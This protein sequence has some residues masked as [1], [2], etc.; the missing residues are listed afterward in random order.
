VFTGS[1]SGLNASDSA[2]VFASASGTLS[3]SSAFGSHIAITPSTV[4]AGETFTLVHNVKNLGASVATSVVPFLLVSD[5]SIAHVTGGPVPASKATLSGGASQDFTWTLEA[6][7]SG[8]VV[9][10]ATATGLISGT[11]D[12]TRQPFTLVIRSPGGAPAFEGDAIVY[13]NPV[14]GDTF[15]VAVRLKAD[16][17]KIDVD[18]YNTGYQRV[19]H[20]EYPAA[21]AG[22]WPLE[23]AGVLKWAPGVYLIRI[24]ATQ[25]DGGTQ[26]FPTLRVGVKR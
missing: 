8:T 19:W 13:P 25:A 21:L 9:L 6:L 20:G 22:D 26:V 16:A 7:K 18:A 5:A 12:G 15:S 11:P 10:T 14:A 17:A 3:V 2:V 1:V 4:K 24:R 23:I